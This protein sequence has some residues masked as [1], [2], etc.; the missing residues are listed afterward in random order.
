MSAGF[1]RIHRPHERIARRAGGHD[2]G[3]E[4]GRAAVFSGTAPAPEAAAPRRALVTCSGCGET[5]PIDAVAV[6]RAVVPLAI[7]LPWRP[8]PVFAICPAC[9]RRAWLRVSS[10]AP[11]LGEST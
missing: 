1:D 11:D 2:L 7:V 5:S 6:L 9:R 10:G 3:D 4:A 8:Y